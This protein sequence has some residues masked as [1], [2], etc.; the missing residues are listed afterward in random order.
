MGSGFLDQSR[1]WPLLAVAGTVA[2]L[3]AL[4][5]GLVIETAVSH[6]P[7]DHTGVRAAVPPPGSATGITAAGSAAPGQLAP[8][9]LVQGSRLVDGISV[10]YPHSAVGAVSAAAGDMTQLASTL[11]PDRAATVMRLVADPSYRDAP[12]QSAQGVISERAQLGLPGSG[13]VPAGASLVFD[14]AEYQ[15]LNLTGDQ[16][17]VLLL[18]DVVVT[19]RGQGSQTRI[20]VYPLDMH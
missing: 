6:H 7:P 18:A 17:G 19:Q 13:P 15:V 8:L 11:D 12:Q 2:V 10:G 9:H 14:P 3:L 4:A 16:V 1:R 5:V 20:G